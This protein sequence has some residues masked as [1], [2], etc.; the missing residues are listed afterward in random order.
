MDI[1]VIDVKETDVNYKKEGYLGWSKDY[2]MYITYSYA[3]LSK[4]HVLKFVRRQDAV[5]AKQKAN[6]Q[7]NNALS[8]ADEY[9]QYRVDLQVKR[10]SVSE[11]VMRNWLIARGLM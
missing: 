2:S 4:E 8:A 11:K 1:Y 3:D 10:I 9:C 5:D 6:E 7:V